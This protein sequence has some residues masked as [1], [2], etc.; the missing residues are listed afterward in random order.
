MYGPKPGRMT[1]VIAAALL[2]FA[3]ADAGRAAE[4]T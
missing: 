2:L 3:A 4:I 1:C